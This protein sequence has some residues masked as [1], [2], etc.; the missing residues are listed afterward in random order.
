M[1]ATTLLIDE[2]TCATNFMMRDR[3]MQMLVCDDKEPITPFL[4]K[5]RSLYRDHSKSPAPSVP[6]FLIGGL[7]RLLGVCLR[8]QRD[9]DI[10]AASGPIQRGGGT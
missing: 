2:D 10:A 8:A 4:F 9:G 5:V 3:R 6:V 7:V 1:G